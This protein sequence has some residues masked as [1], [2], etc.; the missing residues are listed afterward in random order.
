MKLPQITTHPILAL[1]VANFIWG[2]ASPIFKWSLFNVHP[3]TL[4]FL[5]FALPAIWI[6]PLMRKDTLRIDARD[7]TKLFLLSFLGITV[8]IGFYFLALQLTSS[9]NAPVIG[10]A[11]P[12]FLII[13]GM[14]ILKEQP[15]LKSLLGGLI[16]FL[17][18]LLIVITPLLKNGTDASVLGNMILIAATL[19]SVAHTILSKQLI[20]KYKPITLVFWSFTLGSLGFLPF[21]GWEAGKYGFLPNLTLQGEIGILFGALFSS[22]LAHYLY[23][24]ALKKLSTLDVGIFTYLDPVVALVIAAPLLHEIPS[25]TFLLGSFLVFLGI[26]VAEG[27][28][29]YHPFHRLVKQS[30]N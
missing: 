22:L 3:F 28:V 8:N 4:A 18:V 2:A 25:A 20:P 21:V 7:L 23:L 27:R 29:H 6:L 24:I 17:G 30:L 26:Y 13:A 15:N 11:G 14:I 1:I 16:G 19:A 5:R 10:S 9:I 12:I